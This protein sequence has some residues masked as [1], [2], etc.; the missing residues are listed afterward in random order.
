[1]GA[2]E[3]LALHFH[4]QGAYLVRYEIATHHVTRHKTPIHNILSTA[5][6]FNISQKALGRLP[7]D[8]NVMPKHV[9]AT[10][11]INKLNEELMY[12][13]VFHA[14]FYWGF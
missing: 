1:M 7:D 6:Q 12:L 10:I 8:G 11:H 13:L 9:G 14:Y 5:P 4:H 3:C 2:P